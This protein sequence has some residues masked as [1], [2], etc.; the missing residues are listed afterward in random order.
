MHKRLF[1]L[2][3]IL[4]LLIF[5]AVLS[6][7]T[8]FVY[9]SPRVKTSVFPYLA[10][11]IKPLD[12]ALN[13]S[14]QISNKQ[15][16]GMRYTFK[17]AYGSGFLLGNPIPNDLDYSVGVNLG[18]YKYDGTNAEQI[19]NDLFNK[20]SLFQA[21]FCNYIYS[22]PDSDIYCEFSAMD[23]IINFGSK[24]KKFVEDITSSIDNVALDQD[25]IKFSKK[26]YAADLTINF[27]FIL[28]S[29]EIIIEDFPPLTLFSDIIKYSEPKKDSLFLRE[30]TIV[31][32]YSFK[33]EN[34]DTGKV[35]NV[36]LIAESF[37]G[38]RMQLSRMFFVPIAFVG[39]NSAGYLRSLPYLIDDEEYLKNRLDTY[40]RY[41]QEIQNLDSLDT[42]PVKL[43]KRVLQCLD[44]IYPALDENARD[45]IFNSVTALLE[46]RDVYL[47]NNYSTAVHNL[48]KMT[49]MPLT[50]FRAKKDGKILQLL[51]VMDDS[52][53]EMH[54]RNILS[55]EDYTK[56]HLANKGLIALI[57]NSKDENDIRANKEIISQIK[58]DI[59]LIEEKAFIK[60]F[61]N[62]KDILSYIKVF[63]EVYKNAGF[64]NIELY[65]LDNNTLG[66]VKDSFTST[67][68]QNELSKMAIENKLVKVNYKLIDRD[69][70]DL[71]RVRYSVWVRY[72]PADAENE[73][74]QRLRNSL[75]KDKKNFNIK[76]AFVF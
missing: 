34:A 54:Q 27:P 6:Q 45:N 63:S 75:L 18:K 36:D 2:T 50:F 12:T 22:E 74:Y 49:Y 13:D 7:V 9:V 30:L 57:Y 5:T 56:L 10:D 20:I 3:L 31:F 39:E 51:S 60:I 64:H 16:S 1:I 58:R 25:Y 15:Y 71:K 48:F 41:L 46:N 70:V 32:D 38:Q 8:E 53:K 44:L 59:D 76:R 66:I 17:T 4:I 40:G 67:I 33:L 35:K 61:N 69:K 37:N 42:R 19:A 24:R 47:I 23:S 62:Q 68:P 28:K 55:D 65:W 11:V 29:N 73:N 21:E 43:L 26:T 52:I 72:N 14:I